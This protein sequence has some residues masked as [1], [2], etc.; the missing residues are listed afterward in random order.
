MPA[1]DPMPS[2]VRLSTW[3]EWA[4]GPE[5]P[6]AVGAKDAVLR[7]GQNGFTVAV[8]ARSDSSRLKGAL[9]DMW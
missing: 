8:W 3:G 7:T 4:Q 9:S 2:G 5:S 1:L 6:V